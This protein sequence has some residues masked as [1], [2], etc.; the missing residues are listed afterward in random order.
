MAERYYYGQ[1]WE[2]FRDPVAALVDAGFPPR[3]AR[4]EIKTAGWNDVFVAFDD[5][6][7]V[8]LAHDGDRWDRWLVRFDP[9][10]RT[11]AAA[12]YE[13]RRL[14]APAKAAEVTSVFAWNGVPRRPLL[15]VRR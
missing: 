11:D 8:R 12:L 13:A 2:S 9:L 1:F 10:L 3:F 15:S 6:W 14:V 5:H 7:G 4:A